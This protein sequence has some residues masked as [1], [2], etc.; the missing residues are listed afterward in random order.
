M[1]VEYLVRIYLPG[2]GLSLNN[3]EE[4]YHKV[5][6]EASEERKG[7]K[8]EKSQGHKEGIDRL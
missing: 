6:R 8:S 1:Q 3:L 5:S 7:D 4:T 2:E